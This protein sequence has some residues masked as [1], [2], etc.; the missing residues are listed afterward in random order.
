MECTISQSTLMW[1]K[2][3]WGAQTLSGHICTLTS[4]LLF[5]LGSSEPQETISAWQDRQYQRLS[6]EE[7]HTHTHPQHKTH[8]MPNKPINIPTLPYQSWTT[9]NALK[10]QPSIRLVDWL[11]PRKR[12]S[13]FC[14]KQI[15]YSVMTRWACFFKLSSE[16][17]VFVFAALNSPG[18]H[19]PHTPF[20]SG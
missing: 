7:T 10:N 1:V 8:G 11:W 13:R 19:W 16:S 2:D 15:I 20:R 17:P 18:C 14:L 4:K 9:G 5:Q 12:C 6:T 3:E